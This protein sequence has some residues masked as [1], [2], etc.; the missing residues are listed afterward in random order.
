[1]SRAKNSWLSLKSQWNQLLLGFPLTL[2]DNEPE[3]M[4]KAYSHEPPTQPVPVEIWPAYPQPGYIR[5]QR[6]LG[7]RVLFS[8]G[9]SEQVLDHPAVQ[10]RPRAELQ[11]LI[12]ETCA[13]LL[14][15]ARNAEVSGDHPYHQ[16]SN[17]LIDC[18]GNLNQGDPERHASLISVYNEA[19]PEEQQQEAVWIQVA[20]TFARI[21]DPE[22]GQ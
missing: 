6:Q 12:T 1:M 4:T 3:S 18:Y 2:P 7:E 9:Q 13:A 11:N 17:H 10:A 20:E 14:T 5:R 15:A 19:I 8:F 16:G 22:R 21:A